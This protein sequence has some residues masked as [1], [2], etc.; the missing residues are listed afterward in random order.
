MDLIKYTRLIPRDCEFEYPNLDAKKKLPKI[1][2]N[3]T[4]LVNSVPQLILI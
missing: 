1:V 4:K 2:N 3:L